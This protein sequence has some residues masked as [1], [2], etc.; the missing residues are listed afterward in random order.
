VVYPYVAQGMHDQWG[1]TITSD[2]AHIF[3]KGRFLS[4]PIVNRETGQEMGVAFPST[5]KLT[6]TE[7]KEYIEKIARFAAE[8]L[9]VVIPAPG[10][11]E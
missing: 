11:I 10:D 9:G 5:T 4:R 6:T 2:E 1:D 8:S 7:F 3:C